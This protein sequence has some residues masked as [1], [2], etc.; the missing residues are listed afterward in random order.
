MNRTRPTI[1]FNNCF[2]S[3]KFLEEL[4]KADIEECVLAWAC[5]GIYD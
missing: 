2:N 4:E 3:D 5:I 1:Q